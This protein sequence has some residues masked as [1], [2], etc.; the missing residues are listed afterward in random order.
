MFCVRSARDDYRTLT[1]AEGLEN[2]SIATPTLL[3]PIPTTLSL[4]RRQRAGV[5][6]LQ[7]KQ[8]CRQTVQRRVTDVSS[9]ESRRA[10][11]KEALADDIMRKRVQWSN[12]W[13][14]K[15]PRGVNW[16][17]VIWCDELHWA[18]GPRRIKNIKQRPGE[19]FRD[20]NNKASGTRKSLRRRFGFIFL[21]CRLRFCMVHS[22]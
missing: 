5:E 11:I 14:N 15:R 3:P 21:H 19:R 8:W 10:T 17:D 16:R 7:R 20:D 12:T 18:T 6:T 13:L 22:I 9:I 4:R 1:I 2:S